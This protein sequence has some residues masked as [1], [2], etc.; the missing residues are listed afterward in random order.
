ME[1]VLS[2]PQIEQRTPEWYEA[3]NNMITASDI[4]AVLGMNKYQS[5]NALLKKKVYPKESLY[6]SA[7]MLHGIK[8]E[9]IARD[10]FCE[11]YG[12]QCEEVGLFVHPE[13]SFIGGSPDGI[14]NDGRLV[15]IKCPLSREIKHEI[16]EHYY[17]QVQICM[18]IL[19]IE[20]CYFIQ[21]QEETIFRKEIL[22]VLIVKRDEE[23]FQSN[24]PIIDEFWKSV[25]DARIHGLID[26]RKVINLKSLE[27][28]VPP[29]YCYI[30]SDNEEAD[31]GD[32]EADNG[33]E[34]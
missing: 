10:K 31:N 25:L 4:A 8:N 28:E 22:D 3:R 33:D 23:W 26:K 1:R 18:E 29:P 21:Y 9:D 6:C 27:N 15:E 16:P 32:E 34:D 12:V 17:P 30:V 19:N 14:C 2:I 11:K 5:K 7:A 20:E 13:Y 24:L